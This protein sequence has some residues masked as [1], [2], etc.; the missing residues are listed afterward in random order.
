MIIFVINVIIMHVFVH[1]YMC[2]CVCMY[3]CIH[4]YIYVFSFFGFSFSPFLLPL[5]MSVFLSHLFSPLLSPPLR[6]HTPDCT[7][8]HHTATRT[9]VHTHLYTYCIRCIC[10]YNHCL[11]TLTDHVV[12]NC[13]LLFLLLF[14]LYWLCERYHQ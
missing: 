12:F 14:C 1:V 2:T 8:I 3:V 4:M 11:W 5:S 9:N 6:G 10:H 7:L 13:L